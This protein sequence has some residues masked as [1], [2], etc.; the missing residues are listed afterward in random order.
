MGKPVTTDPTKMV[1]DE[2]AELKAQNNRWGP[3]FEDML[4]QLKEPASKAGMTPAALLHAMANQPKGGNPYFSTPGGVGRMP[5]GSKT[6]GPDFG[7]MLA[8]LVGYQDPKLANYT[9]QNDINKLFEPESKGG[10]GVTKA[11]LAEGS[12]VTGGYTVPPQFAMNLM[13]LAVEESIVEGRASS[14]PLTNRTLQVPYLDQFETVSAGQSP[15]L[16][17]MVATWSSEAS[18]RVETEPTFN[19]FELTAWELSFYCLASNTLL[20]DSAIALEALLTQLFKSAIAWYTDW[21]Y[22]QGDGVGKPTGIAG[23]AATIG[24]ARQTASR[25]TFQDAVKMHERASYLLTNENKV[26]WLC[27]PSVEHQLWLMNDQSGATAGTGRLVYTPIDAGAQSAIFSGSGIQ[28]R[29]KLLGLPVIFTEKVNKLGT[30]TVGGDVYLIDFSR[31]L[32]GKRSDLVVDFSTQVRFLNNQVAW[33]VLW[34][35]DGAPWF[36]SPITLVDPAGGTFQV[37]YAVRLV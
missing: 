17:G 28:P 12:G 20:A 31:Y 8:A 37:S 10:F 7:K 6:L 5:H 26:A 9:N 27:H 33:R 29:G 25:F 34:R 22:L 23:H 11:A 16:G 21:A 14:L 36:R 13:E 32:L 4:K 1:L 18:T 24:V 35:G 19:A 15:F 30:A 3:V 2:I